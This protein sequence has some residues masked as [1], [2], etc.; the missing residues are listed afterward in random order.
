MPERTEIRDVILGIAE[1]AGGGVAALREAALPV[2]LEGFDVEV[3]YG[4]SAQPAEIAMSIR[5]SIAAG[6]SASGHRVVA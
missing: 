2:H 6:E 3:S 1:G 5:F 4:G